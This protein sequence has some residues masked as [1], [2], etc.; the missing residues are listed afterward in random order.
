MKYQLC[1]KCYGSGWL[2][3]GSFIFKR[4]SSSASSL[5]CDVCHGSMVLLVPEDKRNPRTIA[6]IC[7]AYEGGMESGLGS[8]SDDNPYHPQSEEEEEYEA[9]DIGYKIGFGRRSM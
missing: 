1:P 3:A 7:D 9:W 2:E 6:T 5:P 8:G 4:L